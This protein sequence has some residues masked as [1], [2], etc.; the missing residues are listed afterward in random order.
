MII[1]ALT[2]SIITGLVVATIGGIF[3]AYIR[4]RWT[5]NDLKKNSIIK[6]NEDIAKKLES[7]EKSIWRINKTVLIMAKIIDD[8]TEKAH[9]DLN[10]SLEDIATELLRESSKI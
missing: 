9:G 7:F 8:Q 3:M 5:N 6:R 1:N 4:R 10:S 2:S